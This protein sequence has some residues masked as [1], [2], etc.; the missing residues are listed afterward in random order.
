MQAS[1]YLYM[2]KMNP[3]HI[4]IQLS[5]LTEMES[6]LELDRCTR[7]MVPPPTYLSP[8]RRLPESEAYQS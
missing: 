7:N 3:S 5:V 1:S 8:S 6:V 2:R 4:V